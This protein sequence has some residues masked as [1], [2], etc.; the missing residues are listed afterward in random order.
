MPELEQN[1][2]L[3]VHSVNDFTFLLGQVMLTTGLFDNCGNSHIT[4]QN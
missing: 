3:Y 4:C 1:N 2:L